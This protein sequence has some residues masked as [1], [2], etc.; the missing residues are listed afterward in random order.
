MGLSQNDLSAVAGVNT[1]TVRRY[2]SGESEIRAS[3]LATF[4]AKGLDVHWLLTG[5]GSMHAPKG[6]TAPDIA[7]LAMTAILAARSLFAA[8][9]ETDEQI[10][11]QFLSLA[12]IFASS[13][14]P[15]APVDAT[16]AAPSEDDDTSSGDR[17]GALS[18]P[19]D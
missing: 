5:K 17:S 19:P 2:E 6:P 18:P 12:K 8:L 3:V 11:R 7:D 10:N 16:P 13:P 4:H 15:A 9:G 1:A 14:K